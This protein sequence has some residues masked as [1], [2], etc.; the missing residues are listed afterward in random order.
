MRMVRRQQVAEAKLE[1][2]KRDLKLTEA[3]GP[4]DNSALI[5]HGLLT[6]FSVGDVKD[7][8]RRHIEQVQKDVAHRDREIMHLKMLISRNKPTWP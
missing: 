7:S 3:R 6:G 8:M 1:E 4:K 5:K 2:L